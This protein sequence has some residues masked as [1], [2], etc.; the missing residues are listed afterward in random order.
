M[1]Y[2]SLRF[3]IGTV[4]IASIPTFTLKP[5]YK[6]EVSQFCCPCC[7][8]TKEN[9]DKIPPLNRLNKIKTDITDKIND[10]YFFLSEEALNVASIHSDKQREKRGDYLRIK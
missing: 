6:P 3:L 4:L 5:E 9:E 8:S 7:E 2:R 1:S 10:A